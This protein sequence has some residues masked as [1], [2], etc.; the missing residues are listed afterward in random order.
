MAGWYVRVGGKV[1][2]PLDSAKIKQLAASGKINE[3]TDIS[4]TENGPFVVAGKVKG[5]FASPAK[6]S[7]PTAP[8]A[9]AV[10]FA[11]PAPASTRAAPAAAVAPLSD[12]VDAVKSIGGY[13]GKT[14]LPGE[15]LVDQGRLHWFLFLR[16]VCW[17]VFAILVT[18]TGHFGGE[19]PSI[20]KS[21]GVFAVLLAIAIVSLVSRVL[22]Y[23][24][25][26][27]AVTNKRVVMKQGFIRRKTM[28]L[29]LNK[30]DSLGIDQ[31]LLGRAFNFGT[32]RVAVATE[33][34][35]FKFLANP[36]EFRRQVQ[37]MQTKTQ[38][39]Q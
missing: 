14:L 27:F 6:P 5:L 32:V 33:K 21:L 9:T 29:M 38:P 35:S 28:E 31:G 26:E 37:L 18:V 17:L 20:G 16:P 3:T 13:V 15:Q 2:G 22:T 12:A 30:V 25:S 23:L 34:Q 1:H 24:T 19:D 10:A 7:P 36:L 11:A 4:Q 8:K 39:T